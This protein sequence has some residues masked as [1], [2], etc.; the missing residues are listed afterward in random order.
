MKPRNH[1]K[2]SFRHDEYVETIL[3][4]AEKITKL[5]NSELVRTAVLGQ[6]VPMIQHAS[7]PPLELR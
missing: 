3:E 2:S 6:Y 5:T 7:I 4:Q 1:I